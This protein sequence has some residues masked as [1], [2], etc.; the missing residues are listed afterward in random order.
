M[1]LLTEL[2]EEELMES[3]ETN[4]TGPIRVA[5]E[6]HPHLQETRGSL[7]FYTSSSHTRG[8]ANYGVYSATKAAIINLPQA[9]AD[10]WA[11]D[12]TRVN[13]INPSRTSTPMRTETFG[14]EDPATLLTSNFVAQATAAIHASKDSGHVFDLRLPHNDP[15]PVFQEALL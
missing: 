3:L 10:E 13:C 8:R 11:A 2:T 1:G 6:S 4:L 12:G 15:A 9:L 7:L 14:D 5:Q